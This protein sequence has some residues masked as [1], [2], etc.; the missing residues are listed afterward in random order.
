MPP[1]VFVRFE[2]GSLAFANDGDPS[3]ADSATVSIPFTTNPTTK[4][5]YPL[6][7]AFPPIAAGKT[8]RAS[9]SV[10]FG[11][12]DASS[13]DLAGDV[14][15]AFRDAYPY[16]TSWEDRRPIGALFL[17]TSQKHPQ[18]NPRGWF[19]NAK[20]VDLTTPEGLAKWRARLMKYADDSIKVLK[21]LD[22]QGMITW[23]PEGEEF[24]NATYYGDPRL[25]SRLAPE[26]D[27]VHNGTLGALDEYFRKFRDAGLRV[28]LT[29]RPQTIAFKDGV[30][31]QQL[32]DDPAQ[33][34][35]DKIDYARKRWGCTLFYLDSTYGKRDALD[36]DVMETIAR[37]HPDVL[38]M[39]ENEDFRYFAYTAPLNSFQHQGVTGTPSSVREVYS[40]AFSVLLASATEEQLRA[41]HDALVESVRRGDILIVYAGSAGKTIEAI[42]GIYRDAG[43]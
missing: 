16:F 35:L 24:A 2:S 14:L 5:S 19:Q 3:A 12:S 34:L 17:A 43:S 37:R 26:T 36:A 25:A 29:L 40:Q 39:P 32:V 6:R 9:L 31:S 42:K 1:V 30:P 15:Q 22:A 27:L 38:L 23:D 21:D 13:N 20:D 41:G 8:A 10:T 33:E 18:N 4:L 7:V 11:S 28:G